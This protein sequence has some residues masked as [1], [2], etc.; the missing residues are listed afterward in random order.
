MNSNITLCIGTSFRS[1]NHF[2]CLIS[3]IGG[4]SIILISF[5]SILFL[6]RYFYWSFYHRENHI[7]HNFYLYSMIFSSLSMIIVIVPSVILQC[8]TCSRLCSKFYCQLE[9]FIS[10]LN[11]CVHMFM[12]MM[13]SIIRYDIVL[14][15]TTRKKYIQK[16]P[17]ITVLI[18]WLFGLIFAVPPLFNWNKYISEGLGFHCGLNWFDRSISSRLYLISAFIFVYF[19][20]LIILFVVNIYVYHVIHHLFRRALQPS[21]ISTS[22]KDRLLEEKQAS[23]SMISSN[24]DNRSTTHFGISKL[25]SV[26]KQLQTRR[27]TD[28]IPIVYMMRLNRLRADRRFALS[29]IFLVSEYLLSWTPYAC[30]G[31]LYLFDIRLII[32]Q[33]L[34]ITICAFI[35]KISMIINPFIYILTIKTNQFK[36]ILFCKQCSCQNCRLGKDLIRN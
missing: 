32:E 4:L 35:A 5:L 13:I 27:T 21:S 6:I 12:L 36:I 19:I 7:H 3:R 8:L 30:V 18:C 25:T 28:S 16:Y 22:L 14:H 34:F 10:Y 1:I 31:L 33:P 11:G 26:N 20:P 9:G 23:L 17:Y 29:T 24:N 2:E 15:T